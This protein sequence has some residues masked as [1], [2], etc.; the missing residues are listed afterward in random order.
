[1]SKRHNF[2]LADDVCEQI[3]AEARRYKAEPW[4]LMRILLRIQNLCENSFPRE[5]A[6]V[7][8]RETGIDL[9]TLY[10]YTS[11]YAMIS[12]APRGKYV[13]RM[14]ESAPCHIT[15]ARDVMDAIEYT[16][17]I[18]PGETTPDGLF[19]L[20][21]C[22]CLGM[23]EKSP[24]IMVNDQVYSSLTPGKARDLMEKYIRGEIS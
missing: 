2:V 13:V 5:V 11:F 22:Q 10:S 18:K 24:A 20:E 21:Y 7:V 12:D 1:M 16:L 23:C 8:S 19:T 17:K 15:G 14:C 3:T 6:V 4:Q 9:A